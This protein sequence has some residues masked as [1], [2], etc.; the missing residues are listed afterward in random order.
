MTVIT[1]R[2]RTST[3][4][5][6][7]V[8]LVLDWEKYCS[9]FSKCE[10]SIKFVEHL[11]LPSP[12]NLIADLSKAGL[13]AANAM[14]ACLDIKKQKERLDIAI[15]LLEVTLIRSKLLA[16][17]KLS[18]D[19][20][21]MQSETK[22]SKWLVNKEMGECV[23]L[24]EKIKKTQEALEQL[25]IIVTYP[26]GFANTVDES[27]EAVTVLLKKYEINRDRI[28]RRF[29]KTIKAVVVV[30]LTPLVLYLINCLVN[31]F[32]KLWN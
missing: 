11:G 9:L 1:N 32:V 22:F 25:D 16:V 30:I 19:V 27:I 7:L 4:S 5:E 3:T 18:E 26:S 13:Y 2:K 31:Y 24:K 29:Y 17:A 23:Q 21:R 14:T 12:I 20:A 15:K 28:F 6:P 8:A 10:K